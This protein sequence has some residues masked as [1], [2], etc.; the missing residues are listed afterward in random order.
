[1]SSSSSSSSSTTSQYFTATSRLEMFEKNS[2]ELAPLMKKE[3]IVTI[4]SSTV[5]PEQPDTKTRII[6]IIGIYETRFKVFTALSMEKHE[7]IYNKALDILLLELNI[8]IQTLF[9]KDYYAFSMILAAFYGRKFALDIPIIKDEREQFVEKDYLSGCSQP[10]HTLMVMCFAAYS[11]RNTQEKYDFGQSLKQETY[12]ALKE[13]LEKLACKIVNNLYLSEPDGPFQVRK[14]LLADCKLTNLTNPEI[15]PYEDYLDQKFNKSREIMAIAYKAKAMEFLSQ[16]PCLNLMRIRN[17]S[18]NQHK[19]WVHGMFR[20]I[21]IAMFAYMLCAFPNYG[22]YGMPTNKSGITK[23]SLKEWIPF[24]VLAVLTAQV[25]MAFIKAKDFKNYDDFKISKLRQ[26]KNSSSCSR[27]F[28]IFGKNRLITDRSDSPLRRY[29]QNNQLAFWRIVLVVPLLTLEAARLLIF[30]FVIEK[31][32]SSDKNFWSGAWVLI[33][34]TLELLYCALFAIATVSTLR[35]FH[36]IQSLGFFIHL[37]KKMMKT[38]GMFILIFCTFWFVLAVIHV[39]ISRTLLATSNSF[40]YTVTFQGKFEI[41]G[42]V[43][44]EDRIGILLNCSEYNKTVMEFFDMEYAEASCLFRSTIM[45]FVVFTYIFVT[46]I[47]LVNLLT[48]QL[49]KEYENESKNSAYYKGYLKYEQLTKIE[50]KLYLPPPFSLFYVVLRFW[51]SCFFKYIVIFTT[52]LTSGCCKCSSTAIS[53]LYWRNIVRIVEGYPWGAVRQTDNEIDTKVAEFLRKRPDNAL[54]KLKDLV[55]NYD[56]DVDDEEALKKLGKEIKKFLAKEIG[57]ERERAQSNLENHPRSGS[58][59]D[60]KKKHRL[61]R[62]FAFVP[63]GSSAVSLDQE[64]STAPS[65]DEDPTAE[66]DI[67]KYY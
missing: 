33:P 50:S 10:L 18:R 47:L 62:T 14:V 49:T 41:F 53:S 26:I 63:V 12:E 29:F 37:F 67:P 2:F 57:E 40:L 5:L 44:D 22:T 13:Q 19:L 7:D 23:R 27:F 4:G 43:Q 15:G 56:K 24:Y 61:S 52:W 3:S 17:E 21:Y 30:A 60:P 64:G 1:M 42:E 55:N 16:R 25:I 46:G 65:L 8:D 66:G 11:M 32:K 51:Y 31:K 9:L 34:I 6:E 48:A 36:S 38:V 28:S 35:F 20:G 45:P 58:V 39:S 59:L 54:E